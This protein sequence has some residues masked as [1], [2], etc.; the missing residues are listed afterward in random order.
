M[1]K[2]LEEKR[3]QREAVSNQ[4]PP[5]VAPVQ[6]PVT[7]AV[8]APVQAPVVRKAEEGG[9]RKHWGV[10]DPKEAPVI[11]RQPDATGL[12]QDGMLIVYEA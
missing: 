4:A 11:A 5:V 2:K 12:V 8:Q 9:G 3:Q 10:P 7:S 6:A 1:R